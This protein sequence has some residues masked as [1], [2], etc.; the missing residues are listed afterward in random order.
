MLL[1]PVLSPFESLDYDV[2]NVYNIDTGEHSVI[3]P[4]EEPKP[5]KGEWM[6]CLTCEEPGW[7][8]IRDKE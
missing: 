4:E 3:S 2:I 5:I 6:V 1:V 7:R 8:F